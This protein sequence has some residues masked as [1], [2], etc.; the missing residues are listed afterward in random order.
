[1]SKN[2]NSQ[3]PDDYA[4]YKD[5][6]SEKEYEAFM[7]DYSAD[8]PSLLCSASGHTEVAMLE[9]LLKSNNIPVIVKW[10][11]AGDAL[12]VY[13]A[14]SSMQADLYV[15]SKLLEDAKILLPSK[16]DDLQDTESD[17]DFLDYAEQKK[18]ERSNNAKK[19]ILLVF[20]LPIVAV[21]LYVLW[22]VLI[23]G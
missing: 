13:M 16:V 11:N 8:T 3:T 7:E 23:A 17:K 19:I 5:I 9:A 2:S 10:R 4:N 14:M 18:S 6:M 12:M 20:I 21:I 22:E 1:M 15:P